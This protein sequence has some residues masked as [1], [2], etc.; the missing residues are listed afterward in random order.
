[1]T[2]ALLYLVAGCLSAEL[3][4]AGPPKIDRTIGK[5]PVYKT[6]TPKYG[7]LAFGPE[8]K[9]RVWLVLD[10]DTLYVDRDG[11]GD[12]TGP[13]KKVAAQKKTRSDP[14]ED[15]Y[16]FDVGDVTAGG[17]KHKGLTVYFV[18]LKRY[19]DTSWG[20][21]PE[22]KAALARDPNALTVRL[23]V[24]VRV[25]GIKGGGLGDRLAFMAGPM[26]L[27]GVFQ[28]AGKPA[29]APVVRLGGPLEITFYG[30][31]PSLRVGRGTELDLV[32]GTPGI[33]PG[34]FAML[35]YQDTIP[36]STKPVAEIT[37]PPAKA[38]GPRLKERL[39]LKDRC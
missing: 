1:M 36:E 11:N 35:C 7:L 22:V 28:L 26:D 21:R 39:V 29:D 13:A 32:V 30:E 34:T 3:A 31:R 33:G 17:R 9:D 8:G 37:F 5:E 24:D 4:N 38:G 19:A 23:A 12:L 2:R 20:Q 6:K 16:T 27:T 25:P 10:G 15:G 14:A 18:R